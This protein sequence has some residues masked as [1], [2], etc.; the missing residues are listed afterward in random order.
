MPSH[1]GGAGDSE[2]AAG[3]RFDDGSGDFAIG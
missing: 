3:A 1:F 2:S